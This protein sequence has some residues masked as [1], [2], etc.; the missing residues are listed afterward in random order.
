M[1][2]N[3]LADF[4]K[5]VLKSQKNLSSYDLIGSIAVLEL[6]SEL[7][8]HKKEIANFLLKKN[9]HIKTVALR[10]KGR[11][12]K[13]RIKK[14]KVIAGE[15]TSKTINT[16]SGCKFLM[17]LNKVYYTPRFSEERLRIAR[18]I[19]KNERVLVLFSGICPYPIVI[20]KK[21]S[22]ESITAI[23]LNKFAHKFA[24]KNIEI[25]KCKKIIAINNDVKKEL[26]K[27]IYKNSFHRIIMPHPTNALN[28][29]SQALKCLKKQGIIHIYLFQKEKE[30]FNDLFKKVQ[31]KVKKTK[32]KLF[33]AKRVRPYSK[34]LVQ[35]V[36]DIKVKK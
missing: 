4:V 30:D 2:V 8:K 20:E 36:L 29:F 24:I 25:N 6:P 31:K 28:Y 5:K 35:V 18:Q 17:D 13:F 15:K 22:P 1:E 19:E 7:Q 21:S 23:E 34:N 3:N 9:K 27:T 11:T 33:N 14:I 12:K 32:L 26:K 16:E 10:Q